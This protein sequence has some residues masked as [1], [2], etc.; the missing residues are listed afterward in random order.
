MERHERDQRTDLH[1]FFIWLG[2]SENLVRNIK[3]MIVRVSMRTSTSLDSL[4]NMPMLDFMEI[5]E[6][7]LEA[8]KEMEE[9]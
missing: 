2:A 6:D 1:L 8:Q 4:R 5:V 9:G 3:K 7:I